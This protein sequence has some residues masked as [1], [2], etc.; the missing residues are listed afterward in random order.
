MPEKKEAAV[1][2]LCAFF[3]FDAP[4]TNNTSLFQIKFYFILSFNV[5]ILKLIIIVICFKKQNTRRQLYA[6]ARVH[7]KRS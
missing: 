1:D 7:G 2:D 5:L 6:T 3:N 4:H